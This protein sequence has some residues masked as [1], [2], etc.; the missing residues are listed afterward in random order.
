[1][2]RSKGNAKLTA[3]DIVIVKTRYARGE[4]PRVIARSFGLAAETIRRVLRGETW[5]WLIP[6]QGDCQRKS[7]GPT[8]PCACGAFRPED[9]PSPKDGE[10]TEEE[11]TRLAA[12]SLARLQEK[13][14]T[15][16]PT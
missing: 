6:E 3:A 1:M 8:W 10:K 11:W 12:E 15:E 14:K 9:C 13:L 5:A 4:T 7:L 16:K 2:G